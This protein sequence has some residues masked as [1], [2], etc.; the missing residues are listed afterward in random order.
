MQVEKLNGIL[1]DNE[2]Y[3]HGNEDYSEDDVKCRI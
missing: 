3:Q 1:G 2:Y